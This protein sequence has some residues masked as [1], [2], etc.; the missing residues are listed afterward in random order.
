MSIQ[1]QSKTTMLRLRDLEAR[2]GLKR[3]TIYDRLNPKSPNY[4][5]SFPKRVLMGGRSIAWVE[6]EVEQWIKSRIS[7]RAI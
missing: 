6:A 1:I 5:A 7:A 3:S 4:D 2:L